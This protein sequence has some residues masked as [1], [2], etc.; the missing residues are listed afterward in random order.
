MD[1][2]GVV[3]SRDGGKTFQASNQGFAQRQ[4]SRIVADP[5]KNGHF[6]VALLHDLEFGGVYETDNHG[7]SWQQLSGGLEGRDVLSLLVVN[8]PTGKLLAGTM[9]GVFEYSAEKLAW[10]N[11]SRWEVSPGKFLKP[12]EAVVVQDLFQRD[13][14]EPIYAATS[15]GLFASTD[16][17][18]WKRLPLATSAGGFYA[19]R[20][21]GKGGKLMLV[22]TSTTLEISP[23]GGQR[24]SRLNLEEDGR[25]KVH[26][27]AVHPKRPDVIFVGTETG[28][29]R[30]TDAGLLWEKFGRG[31]PVSPISEVAIA[32]DD[33]L[34]IFVASSIGVFQSLDG[35]NR[36]QRLEEGLEELLVQR[37][38][39]PPNREDIGLLVTSAYNGIFFNS[40]WRL[41]LTH[42]Q[43]SSQ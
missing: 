1:H 27:I 18:L 26:S 37:V 40:S 20:T 8:R 22:A 15:S 19:V 35:G 30:S 32:P 29:F 2:A 41:L 34:H 39:I 10:Q 6:Y 3:E 43:E 42:L 28:L 38:V 13:P 24:W 25:L 17:E 33:P 9:T 5:N 16:G 11:K 14:A 7:A 36:Y 12:G 4:V 31:V 21:S 23:D